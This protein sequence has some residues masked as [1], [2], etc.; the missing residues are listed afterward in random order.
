MP[1][2]AT[3]FSTCLKEAREAAGLT[4]SEFSRRLG[5]NQGQ[6]C[7]IEAGK[8]ALLGTYQRMA[9]VLDVEIV[10]TSEPKGE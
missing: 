7:N 3:Q 9:E 1:S 4:Q 10:V 2:L 6:L 8:A 5:V